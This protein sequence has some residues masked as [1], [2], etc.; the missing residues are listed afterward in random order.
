MPIMANARTIGCCSLRVLIDVPLL[1]W[2]SRV[3]LER[4]RHRA[5]RRCADDRQRP[6]LALGLTI[7]L[8]GSRCILLIHLGHDELTEQLN[9]LDLGQR[10][11]VAHLD[12]LKVADRGLI[13]HLQAL[14]RRLLALKILGLRLSAL[15]R[16][17][18]GV[19]RS[20]DTGL[21]TRR[22]GRSGHTVAG[23]QLL[24]LLGEPLKGILKPL[25]LGNQTA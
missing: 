14:Q 9:L 11:L 21:R 19:E 18:Q 15:E 3:R 16:T 8:I 5:G 12:R 20:I 1:G 23:I 7:E 17:I 2:W 25:L 6:E 13:F 4:L 10:N 24:E 22:A